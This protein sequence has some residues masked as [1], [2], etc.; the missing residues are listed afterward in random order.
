MST[1]TLVVLLLVSFTTDLC[2]ASRK[3]NSLYQPPPTIFTYHNGPLLEGHIP[4]SILWYGAFTPNQK[5]IVSDFILSLAPDGRDRSPTLPTSV[6]EWW[7]TVDYY[8][9]KAGKRTTEI[10]L[11]NQISD[12]GYSLGKLL[13]RAQMSELAARLGVMRGGAAVVLTAADVAVDGFC[14]SA[15]GSHS[16]SHSRSAAHV[17]VGD[18]AA[19]CPGR[20]AWPFHV[21]DYYGPRAG[22]VAALGAP[23]GDVGV[24]GMVTNLA[25]LLAGAVTN[26]YG[27]GYYEGD[28]GAPVEVGAACPGAYGRGAYPGYAGELRVDPVSGGSYNVVGVNGR[29]YLVPALWDPVSR[30]CKIPV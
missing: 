15:C 3:L 18:S 10:I 27:G 24:D 4:I 16:H 9:R 5:A 11:S 17:W 2:F 14:T 28:G 20:C 7:E 23:N 6:A 1:T 30:S 26:P 29:K 25:I 13:N 22:H 19:Q 12:A 21:A 8:V